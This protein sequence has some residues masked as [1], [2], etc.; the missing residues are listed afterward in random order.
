MSSDHYKWGKGQEWIEKDD[1]REVYRMEAGYISW[2]FSWSGNKCEGP[3]L[4]AF[5]G[6]QKATT[7]REKRTDREERSSAYG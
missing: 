7:D 4:H 1:L 5:R 3:K 2:Y 6:W